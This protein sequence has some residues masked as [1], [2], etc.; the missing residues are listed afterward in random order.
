MSTSHTGALS[1]HAYTIPQ[2]ADSANIVTAFTEFSDTI[3]AYPDVRIDVQT[4]TGDQ[5]TVAQTVY[6]YEGS[7]TI[8]LTLPT[9]PE[10]G[11]RVVAYQLGDGEITLAVGGGEDVGGG[12]PASGS[13]YAAVSAVFTDGS[14]Y[15]LLFLVGTLPEAPVGGDQTVDLLDESSGKTF[16]YHIFTEHRASQLYWYNLSIPVEVLA[17]G[18]GANGDDSSYDTEGVGGLGGEYKFVSATPI[19]ADY[20][21]ISVKP[22]D[23]GEDSW[24]R[25]PDGLVT[26][27]GATDTGASQAIPDGFSEALGATQIGGKGADNAGPID[28]TTYGGGGAGG[29]KLLEPYTQS[30]TSTRTRRVACTSMTARMV[31]GRRCTSQVQRRSLVTRGRNPCPPPPPGYGGTTCHGPCDC[32]TYPNSSGGWYSRGQGGCPPGWTISGCNCTIQQ[33]IYSTRYYCDNG[34]TNQNNGNCQKT[35]TGD[36]TQ[37][38]TETRYTDCVSGMSPIDRVCTM[39]GQQ[40]AV[41]GMAALLS[42]VTNCHRPVRVR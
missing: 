32:M 20:Q 19:A 26:A 34:G 42:S 25:L 2:L 8:T 18:G 28:A 4:V 38:I 37:T 12:I 11:D 29:F 35:C 21:I 13:K 1:G 31:R 30:R 41:K 16:R 27:T 5:A 3:P 39:T 14:W 36:D 23:V 22:G 40:V 10:E 7:A 6:L 15:F 24:I 33:P 17:I 9:P